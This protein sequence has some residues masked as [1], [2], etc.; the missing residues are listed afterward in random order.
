MSRKTRHEST[1]IIA[2]L[3]AI[4]DAREDIHVILDVEV[5]KPVVE[6]SNCTRR[7]LPKPFQDAILSDYIP[8]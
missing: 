7:A 4:Q 3:S 8:N 6:R 5:W 1:P 2:G